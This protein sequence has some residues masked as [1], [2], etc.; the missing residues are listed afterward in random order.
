MGTDIHSFMEVRDAE[1]QPWRKVGKIFPYE[2]Y[3][4]ERPTVVYDEGTDHEW[5][6]NAPLTDE[7]IGVRNYRLF[8]VL[9]DVRN[10]HGFAGAPTG[11]RIEP[12]PG[13]PRG[14]PDDVSE[15]VQKSLDDWDGHSDS[16]CLL[17]E[18]LDYNWDAPYSYT[19]VMSAEQYEAL[20]DGTEPES[21]SGFISG[22]GIIVLTEAQYADFKRTGVLAPFAD[23]YGH[24]SFAGGK[25]TP[26]IRLHVQAHWASKTGVRGAVGEHWVE[27]FQKWATTYDPKNTR[28]VYYF[29]S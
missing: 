2:Y 17:Q 29:D 8:S 24:W 3:N 22:R 20:Q 21:W 1:D 11:D 16:W 23:K 9:A 25:P 10:G 15:E 18:L 12:L 4:P 28:F 14:F 13:A 26:E 19:G 6:S 27:Q 5:E 7:P